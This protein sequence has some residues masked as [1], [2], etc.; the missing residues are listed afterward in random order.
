MESAKPR[1]A[2]SE[3][4]QVSRETASIS[5]SYLSLSLR[6]LFLVLT[7]LAVVLMVHYTQTELVQV[8]PLQY[9]FL[10]SVN[11]KSSPAFI[12]FVV[13][14]SV[15]C[16]HSIIT[17]VASL[18]VIRKRYPSTKLLL[19]LVLMDVLMLG[20]VASATGAAG[21][22][23]YIGLKGNSHAGWGKVCSVYDKFCRHIGSS[24]AISLF[25]SILL[26]LLVMLSVHGLYCHSR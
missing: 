11:F 10:K 24:I 18:L 2:S 25:A 3:V 12:Y 5:F 6:I 20:I 1:E 14:L 15:A 4:A 17:I 26:V 13:A 22:V 8:S 9:P 7:I 16:L 23:G 21:A 19:H